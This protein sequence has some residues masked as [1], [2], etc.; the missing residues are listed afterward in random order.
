MQLDLEARMG[1]IK[2]LNQQGQRTKEEQQ[3][4]EQQL[5]ELKVNNTEG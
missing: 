1:D 2:A 3:R 4:V 5:K